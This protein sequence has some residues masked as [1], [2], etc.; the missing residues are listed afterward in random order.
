MYYGTRVKEGKHAKQALIDML[1]A[2][3]EASPESIVIPVAAAAAAAPSRAE[4]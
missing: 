2:K 3:I 1:S 4:T